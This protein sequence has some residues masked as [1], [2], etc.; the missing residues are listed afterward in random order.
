M[1]RNRKYTSNFMTSVVCILS[2][3]INVY[4]SNKL[5]VIL[6]IKMSKRVKNHKTK[7]ESNID[8]HFCLI[9]AM[10]GQM[11]MH[12]SIEYYNPFFT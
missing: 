7:E 5:Q 11:L 12:L 6:F 8:S 4:E 3:N 9:Q 1:Y 10:L 2:F